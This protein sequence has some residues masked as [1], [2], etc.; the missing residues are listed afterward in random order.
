MPPIDTRALTN[1]LDKATVRADLLVIS[2][3]DHLQT[4]EK[5]FPQ[6]LKTTFSALNPCFA[7]IPESV[8]GE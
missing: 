3:R 5:S 4:M 8:F 7:S 6:A 1:G 2:V